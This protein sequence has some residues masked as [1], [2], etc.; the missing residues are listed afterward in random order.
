[1]DIVYKFCVEFCS[2]MQVYM[3]S[4]VWKSIC[5]YICFSMSDIMGGVCCAP[6]NSMEVDEVADELQVF[7]LVVDDKVVLEKCKL[8]TKSDRSI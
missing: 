3:G 7:G 1:M 5:G 6:L 4:S 2:V 8:R